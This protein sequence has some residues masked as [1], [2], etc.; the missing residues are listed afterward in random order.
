HANLDP[1][2]LVQALYDS[3]AIVRRTACAALAQTRSASAIQ[4]LADRLGDTDGAVRA[5][6]AQTLRQFGS[7]AT[8]IALHALDAAD[9][10]TQTAAL[11]ALTS[12]PVMLS[13]VR[14]FAQRQIERLRW[15]RQIDLGI[16]DRGRHA[17]FLRALIADRAVT[18]E[19]RLIKALGLLGDPNAM[20]Q[21]GRGLQAPSADARAAAV[22]ALDTLGDKPLVKQI[23]PLLEEAQP[24]ERLS[25]EAALR[26]CL[27]SN[28]VWLCAGAARAIP[29][30]NAPELSPL[31]RALSI[32]AE[33]LAGGA[34][35][36]A[37][38][39]MNEVKAM[40]TLQTM[41]MMER[42]LLLHEVPLFADLSPDDLAQIAAIARE[43]WHD[44]GSLICREGEWGR[45]MHVVAQ[46]QVR[47]TKQ[48]PDSEKFLATRYAGDFIGEMS[49]VLATPRTSSVYAA[50]E[51]RTLVISDEALKTILHDRPDVAL[52]MMRGVMQRFREIED[53]LAQAL[54]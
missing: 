44:D 32:E 5:A 13:P 2:P 18:C 28:D 47:V 51:V 16:P 7:A 21:V 43:Q 48:T 19:Q 54:E 10:T 38:H 15:L 37:L 53:R 24:G 34:A 33:S 29:E 46:G 41:S 36:D 9:E 8:P 4:P 35:H 12:D 27:E 6:A 22:E 26:Q 39:E 52:L 14:A 40:E 11:E 42:V 20:Q 49:I 25:I 1:A 23:I 45:E 30:L 17:R 3:S 50:G 31:L